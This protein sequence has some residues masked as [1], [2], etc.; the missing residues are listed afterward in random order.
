MPGRWYHAGVEKTCLMLE[1]LSYR[2]I[3]PDVGLCHRD[4]I[5]HFTKI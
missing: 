3:E 2:V 1:S 5:I 4:P